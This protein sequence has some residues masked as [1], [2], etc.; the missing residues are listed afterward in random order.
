MQLG[1]KQKNVDS[2]TI[3][4]YNDFKTVY[5][6]FCCDVSKHESNIY[7]SGSTADI[8]IKLLLDQVP[9]NLYIIYCA[10]FSERKAIMEVLDTKLNVDILIIFDLKICLIELLTNKWRNF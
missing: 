5:P 3:V 8:E 9:S 2:G 1:Y 4:S 7:Q 6:L 10:I